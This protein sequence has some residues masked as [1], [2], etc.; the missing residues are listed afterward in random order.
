MIHI[1]SMDEERKKS[2]ISLELDNLMSRVEKVEQKE[3][4]NS[5]EIKK[6]QLENTRLWTKMVVMEQYNRRNNIIITEISQRANENLRQIVIDWARK[7]KFIIHDMEIAAA[8]RFHSKMNVP[9]II[10]KLT[11]TD[12]V[13]YMIK[14]KS[15]SNKKTSECLERKPFQ[16]VCR[17]EYLKKYTKKNPIPS[18]LTSKREDS[19]VCLEKRRFDVGS[20]GGERDT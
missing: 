9:D 13:K 10:V 11:N 14:K 3:T 12:K 6:L 2:Q 8:H 4:E 16:L 20:K 19:K 15:K 18:K 5:N 17:S 1:I 7:W